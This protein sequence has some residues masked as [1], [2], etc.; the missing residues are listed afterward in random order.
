MSMTVQLVAHTLVVDEMDEILVRDEEATDAQYLAEIAGRECYQSHDK[1]YPPTAANAD[2]IDNIL[3]KEHFSVLEHAG[4]TVRVTGVSR[5]LSHELVRHR[6][7]SPSQLSQRYVDASTAD[8]VTH[9][10]IEA[11]QDVDLREA[12]FS[13]LASVWEVSLQGYGE[14]QTIFEQDA[15]RAGGKVKKKVKNQAARMVL[16]NM[17]ETKLI[18]TGNHRAWMEFLGKRLGVNA[19]TEIREM[20]QACLAILRP[21][22][23]DLYLGF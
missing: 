6:H 12:A 19:D 1:D 8:Y 3:E 21:I 5:A 13:I 20:A 22:A 23:P 15:E 4:V 9:P 17:T 16:P 18:L 10:D 7:M 14:L 11:I 2:Y